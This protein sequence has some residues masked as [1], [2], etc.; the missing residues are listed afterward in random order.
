MSVTDDS[1]GEGGTPIDGSLQLVWP[2]S[3]GSL[4][5]L[6]TPYPGVGPFLGQQSLTTVTALGLGR[7]ALAYAARVVRL[8]SQWAYI[9][10]LN[11]YSQTHDINTP[12]RAALLLNLLHS[13]GVHAST[14]P[15]WIGGQ[16]GGFPPVSPPPPIPPAP[17]SPIPPAP[18]T[19]PQPGQYPVPPPI[20]DPGGYPLP[21]QDY[22]TLDHLKIETVNML[23]NILQ[24]LQGG[25]GSNG[26]PPLSPDCCTALTN[27]LT[28]I[29]TTLMAIS[30]VIPMLTA[31]PAEPV[32]L[33]QVVSAL[34]AV[35]QAL[36]VYLAPIDAVAAIYSDRAGAAGKSSDRHTAVRAIGRR[37]GR[38]TQG[39]LVADSALPDRSAQ[40][41]PVM[42][43]ASCTRS[44]EFLVAAG[45]LL[46][47]F[48][49]FRS[50]ARQGTLADIVNLAR[51]DRGASG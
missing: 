11:T 43:V 16:L 22:D 13:Q 38:R 2:F 27:A 32:D 14:D 51:D 4:I 30:T 24:T 34:N 35:A 8:T 42:V 28:A 10:I 19:G 9:P 33:T 45:P 36:A 6:Y 26:S 3:F 7:T 12:E 29:N 21:G 48:G 41:I 18:P 40:M 5:D 50:R 20:A 15:V 49:T 39:E 1:E 23:G 47:A 17:P 25:G 37:Y 46:A 44:G 31:T